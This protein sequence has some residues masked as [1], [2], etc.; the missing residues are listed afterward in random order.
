MSERPAGGEHSVGS[1]EEP[2]VSRQLLQRVC[3]EERGWP[4]N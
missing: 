4:A 3:G 1:R 2:G